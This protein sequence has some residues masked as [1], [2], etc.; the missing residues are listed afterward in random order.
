MRIADLEYELSVVDIGHRNTAPDR[1]Y[2][3]PVTDASNASYI[4]RGF[5]DLVDKA[6]CHRQDPRSNPR[7]PAFRD[8]SKTIDLF[9]ACGRRLRQI[10]LLLRQNHRA[11]YR[12]RDNRPCI[13][14]QL[15]TLLPVPLDSLREAE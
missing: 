15:E 14:R 3:Q 6:F 7:H 12:D 9:W 13:H 11:R 2:R 4:C 1:G 5:F 8:E 10:H